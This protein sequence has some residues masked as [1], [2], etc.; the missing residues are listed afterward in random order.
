[1]RILGITVSAAGRR[2]IDKEHHGVRIFVRLGFASEEDA[3][4]RL[5]AEMQSVE[6]ELQRSAA[7]PRFAGAAARYLDESR[8][9]RSADVTAWHVRLLIPY[10]GTLELDRIHD[11]T[12]QRFIADRLAG[13]V[14]AT[15]INRSLEVVRTIL[16]R[17]A[18]VYRDG[19]GRPWLAGVPPLIATL[20]ETRRAPYPIT[21][22]EQDRLFAKLPARLARMVLFAVNTGL[23]ES[24][25]AGCNGRG[26]SQ[27][28]KLAGVCS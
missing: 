19:K 6:I 20:S 13:G 5:A 23:R 24:N 27:S 21:W 11:A 25:V 9:L 12:L 3:L 28:L 14:T 22:E 2:I 26:K 7:R 17:S 18:R 16:N 15:T 10:I 4:R 1:M 8:D